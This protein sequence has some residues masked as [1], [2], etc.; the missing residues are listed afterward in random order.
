M[1]STWTTKT[2]TSEVT[3]PLPGICV[4]ALELR[5][6]DEKV[7]REEAGIERQG[8]K[9]VFSTRLGTPV[10]PRNFNR[11]WDTRIKKAG[12]RR[13]TVHD[14]RRTCGTLLADLDVHPA[15]AD[16]V[17]RPGHG[18]SIAKP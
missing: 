2:E 16:N 13:I 3:L 17:V 11:S 1:M 14:A 8:S 10:E 9:L 12:V 15:G 4:A 7:A 18:R 5:R 6:A